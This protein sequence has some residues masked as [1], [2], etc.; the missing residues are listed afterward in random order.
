MDTVF[1]IIKEVKLL[2]FWKALLPMV[3]TELGMLIED[4]PLQP[5]KA[6]SSI[7]VTELPIETVF[8]P[9]QFWNAHSQ[10][11]VTEFGILMDNRPLH[12]RKAQSP[13]DVTVF[14]I[15]VVLQPTISLFV[16]V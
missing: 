10:I 3:V 9:V 14:G 12:P 5:L 11:V 8:K 1:G 13:I 6:P 4:K 15:T 2:Q 7:E 16:A